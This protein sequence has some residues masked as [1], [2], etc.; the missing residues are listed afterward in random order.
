VT[1][2]GQFIFGPDR[3]KRGRSINTHRMGIDTAPE[4]EPPWRRANERGSNRAHKKTNRT[5]SMGL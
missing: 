2:L 5:K 4:M 1:I 3:R